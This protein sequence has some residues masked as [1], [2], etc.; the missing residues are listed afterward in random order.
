MINE[1]TEML[2]ILVL[3]LMNGMLAMSEIAIITARKVRLQR[4][5]EKGNSRAA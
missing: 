2:I 4:L 3:I 1:T 5:T